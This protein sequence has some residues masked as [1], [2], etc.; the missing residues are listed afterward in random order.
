MAKFAVMTLR[1][2]GGSVFN[3][4]EKSDNFIRR[5]ITAFSAWRADRG[6]R[7]VATIRPRNHQQE[8]GYIIDIPGFILRWN[9]LSPGRRKKRLLK[10]IRLIEEAGI[11]FI[12]VPFFYSL[13]PTEAVDFLKEQLYLSDGSNIRFITLAK[14]IRH[15]MGI[16]KNRLADIEAGIWCADS[17]VG[18]LLAKELVPFLNFIMLGGCSADR[19][20]RLSDEIMNEAGLA[21]PVTTD[22]KECIRNRQLVVLTQ[23]CDVQLLKNASIVVYAGAIDLD[24]VEEIRKGRGPFWILSGWPE[25]P[26]EFETSVSLSPWEIAGVLESMMQPVDEDTAQ[27][28]SRN[29]PQKR[30]LTPIEDC[31]QEIKLKG[32]ISVDGEISYD[33][34]RMRYFRKGNQVGSRY[35]REA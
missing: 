20:F 8:L 12:C 23:R 10:F 1:H 34:F 30:Q 31:F 24:F 6:I 25:L 29:V 28:K 32:C 13:L 3:K 2:S 21:C 9:M 35:F 26:T 5:A 17:N 7:V 33:G 14:C 11:R 18:R 22:L 19:L 4:N 16:L 27:I 15:L